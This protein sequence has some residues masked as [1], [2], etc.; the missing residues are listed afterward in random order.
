[1]TLVGLCACKKDHTQSS[2]ISYVVNGVTYSNSASVAPPPANG[3][4]RPNQ[5]TDLGMI[6][7][8]SDSISTLAS[9]AYGA[10]GGYSVVS[11]INLSFANQDTSVSM[12]KPGFYTYRIGTLKTHFDTV[13]VDLAGIVTFD[14]GTYNFYSYNILL[15]D[16][17]NI[18]S[19][20]NYL[21]SGTFEATF[22]TKL[23]GDSIVHITNGT[24][25]NFDLSSNQVIPNN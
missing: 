9:T 11:N 6:W 12:V 7:L 25:T 18:T 5:P 3:P 8:N 21:A 1:M 13:N 14:Q 22:S 20:N 24:F 15:S 10:T 19:V 2:T 23:G 17:V 4:L 16:T